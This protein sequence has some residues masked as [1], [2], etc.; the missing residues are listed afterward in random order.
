MIIPGTI[1]PITSNKIN[2]G[3]PASICLIRGDWNDGPWNNHQVLAIGYTYNTDIK[4]LTI[5]LYDP[6]HPD[7]TP[8][9]KLTFGRKKYKLNID[10]SHSSRHIRGFFFWPYDR[11]EKVITEEDFFELEDLSWFWVLW[12]S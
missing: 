5:Y 12:G 8:N 7:S 4:S 11:T 6:N 2:A 9:L 10:H 1:V 3:I